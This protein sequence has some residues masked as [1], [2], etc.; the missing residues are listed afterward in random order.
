MVKAEVINKLVATDQLKGVVATADRI[1]RI[2]KGEA[3]EEVI[4]GDLMDATEKGLFA[5]YSRIKSEIDQ[6]VKGGDW[7]K[8]VQILSVLTDPVEKFFIDVLVMHED[9]KLRLNRLALLG[10]IEKLYLE[11]ADFKKIVV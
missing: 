6:V 10:S 9:E 5:L 2:V 11:I 8:A 4:E 1:A 7:E 3:R